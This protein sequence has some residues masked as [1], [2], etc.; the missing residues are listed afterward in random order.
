MSAFDI[1][2][3]QGINFSKH[4]KNFRYDPNWGYKK[5]LKQ[6]YSFDGLDIKKLPLPIA[7]EYDGVLSGEDEDEEAG[8]LISDEEQSNEEV[9]E[10]ITTPSDMG[11]FW[12]D[13]FPYEVMHSYSDSHAVGNIVKLFPKRRTQSK[14]NSPTGTLEPIVQHAIS[15]YDF[16]YDYDFEPDVD[17][18]VTLSVMRLIYKSFD[19]LV[20]YGCSPP[21][22]QDWISIFDNFEAS[23]C[24]KMCELLNTEVSILALEFPYMTTLE[25]HPEY[26]TQIFK[27]V[28]VEIERLGVDKDKPKPWFHPHVG[29]LFRRVMKLGGDHSDLS[30]KDYDAFKYE[31][32]GV[33]KV[34]PEIWSEWCLGLFDKMPIWK[35]EQNNYQVFSK[36]SKE[37]QEKEGGFKFRCPIRFKILQFIIYGNLKYQVRPQIM[38]D[39]LQAYLFF[40]NATINLLMKHWDETVDYYF[41]VDISLKLSIEDMLSTFDFIYGSD[42]LRAYENARYIKS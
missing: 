14:P 19:L 2:A 34:I 12:V 33:P 11:S 16:R 39:L 21:F 26:L 13:N 32:C 37:L 22:I 40:N 41:G 18:D 30:I 28:G 31:K 9:D 24:R 3:P 15:P 8:E 1:R 6:V 17:N 4:I 38:V 5:I 27:N 20:F 36:L 42:K 35:V 10:Y 7:L 23:L 25:F 29:A